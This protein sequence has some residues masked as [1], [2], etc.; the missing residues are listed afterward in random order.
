M[1]NQFFPTAMQCSDANM[2]GADT[3]DILAVPLLGNRVDR[4]EWNGS[5][6]SYDSN[7][8]QLLSFQNDGAPLP[9]GQGDSSQPPRGNHDGG[10]IAF[11]H[12]EKLYVM[13]GDAGRR[14]QLQNLPSGPTLTGL[15]P[16]VA[17]DQFGG[18][19]P[20]NAHFTG[21]ILRLND[22][23][24]IP[25]DNPFYQLGND[26]GGQVGTNIQKIYAYGIRNSFGMAFDP[27]TGNL[28]DQENGEDAFDELNLIEPGMNSG[29]IQIIGPAARVPEYRQI[30]TT[31]LHHEATPN[32]QQLRWGPDRIA[33]TGPEAL[34]RLFV[35]PGS[36]YSDPEFSWKHVLAPAAIG[37]VDSN[38][39][40]GDMRNDLLVGFSVPEPL[41]G[42][43]MS[44]GLTNNRRGIDARG[45]TSDLV[46][47]N[48]SFH[49]PAES[50][51]FIIGVDFGVITDI[52]TAPDGTV[53]I[54]SIDKGSV[55][56][57]SRG[58]G[59]DRDRVTRLSANLRGSAEVPGPGDPDGEGSAIAFVNQEQGRL[60]Y[61][62]RV[63]DIQTATLAHIHRGGRD[64]AGP[65]VVDLA[66]PAGG[67]SSGCVNVEADLLDMLVSRPDGFYVNV[68]NAEFPGGA[69]RGQLRGDRGIGKGRR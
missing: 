11:G 23:G 40:G 39:L 66:A 47:D 3:D 46:A 33:T 65:V 60:C 16:T 14:S 25:T 59:D 44:F 69:V 10:V 52:E 28:W 9:A 18:P 13:F 38:R 35:L 41:G 43:L 57:L 54:V 17:D 58:Q 37:F 51:D 61:T 42:P 20:D 29:W 8:I 49:D 45:A 50:E 27:A 62:L 63:S 6:L 7:L 36:Q 1:V 30:E 22:D 55:F 34:S 12:D 21:V 4:F 2:F 5:T 19:T 26:I 32:L 68:H 67:F 64:E 24:T 15:G 31:S 53:Y 48:P 56:E